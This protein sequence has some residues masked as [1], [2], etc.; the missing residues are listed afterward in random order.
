MRGLVEL[1]V[2]VDTEHASSTLACGSNADTAHL[3]SEETGRHT[4]H[5]DQRGEAVEI[6]ERVA[7]IAY[8]GIFEL[9]HSMG[10][11]I[12]VL[13]KTLKSYP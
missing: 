2:V 3:R 1:L 11:V 10:K 8:P 13:P 7:R 12:G 4:G 6:P 9:C 5:D